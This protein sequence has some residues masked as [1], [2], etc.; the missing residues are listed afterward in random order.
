MITNLR[1]KMR[2]IIAAVLIALFLIFTLLLNQGEVEQDTLL[3]DN[4]NRIDFF[5]TD[6]TLTRWSVEGAVTSVTHTPRAEHLVNANQMKL[7]TPFSVGYRQNGT[8]EHTINADLGFFADDNSQLD[9]EGSVELHHNPDSEKDT[10]LFTEQLSYFPEQNLATSDVAVEFLNNQG[11]TKGV[12][13]TLNT[14][15]NTLDLHTKVRGA[16]VA[17]TVDQ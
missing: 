17:S 13:M 14:E 15:L 7:T 9:L 11:S 12:G 4:P 16:Y 1:A 10:A 3:K 6:A 2:L 5:V 8:T